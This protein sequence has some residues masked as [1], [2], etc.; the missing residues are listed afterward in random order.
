M[1]Y[2]IIRDMSELHQTGREITAVLDS[3]SDLQALIAAEGEL[4]PGSTAVVAAKGRPT[5]ILNASGQWV[6]AGNASGGG[7]GEAELGELSLTLVPGDAGYV[8]ADD[9]EYPGIDGWNKVNYE[10]ASPV[11]ESLSVTENGTY[12]P[13]GG[14][15]GFDQVVVAV[16]RTQQYVQATVSTTTL[17]SPL[18]N[19]AVVPLIAET[20]YVAEAIRVNGL[21]NTLLSYSQ[22]IAGLMV[23]TF[24]GMG[25]KTV[26]LVAHYSNAGALFVTGGAS[27][28][29]NSMAVYFE[30][31]VSS[32]DMLEFTKLV[33]V[34]NGVEQDVTA[35]AGQLVSNVT[36]GLYL[37]TTL[38]D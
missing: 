29:N 22:P 36:L 8:E 15:D 24:Q 23:L 26:P 2:K 31:T 27:D 17:T 12:T 7:G 9:P 38:L 20:Q 1:A 5:Y 19:E 11:A 18:S 21:V 34:Q 37:N 3:A 6:D 25:Q 16:P 4:A 10:V 28:S 14:Y 30:A 35:M 13:A 32:S 33:L